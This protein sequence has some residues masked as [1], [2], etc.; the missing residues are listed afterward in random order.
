MRGLQLP[1]LHPAGAGCGGGA[2]GGGTEATAQGEPAGEQDTAGGREHGAEV[3]AHSGRP[4]HT[5]RHHL[6]SQSG[7]ARLLAEQGFAS[8]RSPASL[9]VQ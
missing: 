6:V 1:G 3:R 4:G 5:V 7:G 8:C 2:A 9:V